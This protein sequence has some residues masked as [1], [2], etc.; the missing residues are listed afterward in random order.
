MKLWLYLHLEI[1]QWCESVKFKCMKKVFLF[2]MLC[3]WATMMNAQQIWYVTPTASPVLDCGS[4]WSNPCPLHYA[5]HNAAPGDEIWVKEGYYYGPLVVNVDLTIRGGFA[6]TES[7]LQ[8]R[9]PLSTMDVNTVFSNQFSILDAQHSGSAVTVNCDR[10]VM[11]RFTLTG[12]YEHFGGGLFMLLHR[13]IHLKDMHVYNNT[14]YGEG[15]GLYID[16]VDSVRIENIV[17][18]G[19]TA[20]SRGGGIVF[21]HCDNMLLLINALIAKNHSDSLGGGLV[22]ENTAAKVINTTIVNNTAK[23]DGFIMSLSWGFP[24]FYNCILFEYGLINPPFSSAVNIIATPSQAYI[25]NNNYKDYDNTIFNDFLNDDYRL[26]PG[27]NFSPNCINKGAW[28]STFPF[29]TITTDLDH[30]VRCNGTVD[31]GAYELQ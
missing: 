5:V 13:Y 8:D 12:G 18:Y 10:F 31:I 21:V 7:Q 1:S 2:S 16:R 14:A 6:G 25:D 15:G 3:V 9:A 30:N 26:N 23:I 28:H 19:D 17:V 27:Y 22:F 20:L 11:D 4:S 29:P 24:M